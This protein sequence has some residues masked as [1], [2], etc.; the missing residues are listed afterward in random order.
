MTVTKFLKKVVY[1]SPKNRRPIINRKWFWF[2]KSKNVWRWYFRINQRVLWGQHGSKKR[3]TLI[4]CYFTDASKHL[5][6]CSFWVKLLHCMLCKPIDYKAIFV[7]V[8]LVI[9]KIYFSVSSISSWFSWTPVVQSFF[10]LKKIYPKWACRI[11][12][13]T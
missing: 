2:H 4:I 1:S 5:F 3:I 11:F 13:V 10:S 9:N 6:Y 8:V 12:I 7:Y